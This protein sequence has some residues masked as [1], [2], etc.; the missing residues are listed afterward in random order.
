M[1]RV[2]LVAWSASCL[3]VLLFLIGVRWLRYTSWSAAPSL[4]GVLPELMV[5]DGQAFLWPWAYTTLNA[6]IVLLAVALLVVGL[7]RR[8]LD[9][10]VLRTDGRWRLTPLAVAALLGVMAW[11][12]YLFDLN[13][14]VAVVCATS[15]VLAWLTGHARVTASLPRGVLV[16]VWGG[17]FACC[18]VVA[19]DAI[20]RLTI[21][22]WTVL[23]AA[24]HRYL[25]PR[26]GAGDLAL[27]R[28]AAVI[29]MNLL[30]AAL[31][32]VLVLHGGTRL[33]EGL[34]YSFCEVPGRAVVY[35]AVP[36]CDSV[37][38]AYEDCGEGRVVEYD[39]DTLKRVAAHDFFSPEFH[40]RLELMVCLPDEVQV[41]VQS[42][43]YRG[44]SLVHSVLSFRAADP[45]E[46]NP[47]FATGIGAAMAYDGAHDAVFYSGE[48]NNFI[49]RY[50]R[51]TRQFDDGA[52]PQFVRRWFEPVSLQA[53]DGSMCIH[54]AGIHP[55]RNRMYLTEWMRGRYAYALDLNSLRQ[56]ARYDVGGGGASGVSV[57]VER[58]RLF[59]SSLW[60]LEVYDLAT[61]ALIA[62]KR[63]GLGNRPVI[64]DAARNRLYVSSTVEGKV[65]I[66][67]RDTFDVVGQIPIGIGSRFPHL[68]SDG[69]HLFASSLAA[70]YAWDADTLATR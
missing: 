34:A 56:V 49:V 63:L 20:D 39:R 14:T 33:G 24:T 57:D 28:G 22:V 64:V 5:L 23:L 38:T 62:R 8:L 60:G 41:T 32:L 43:K 59:V 36:V 53:F 55:G 35:A 31:P 61:D 67:D 51:R 26:F 11:L 7:H 44:R 42:A 17:F 46:F 70:H 21:V 66:L 48:F 65:R 9:R 13:P 16:A 10:L 25:G 54:T 1:K 18:V 68:S 58:D 27:L 40:G 45:S 15:L 2:L 50:D 4:D 6:R 29:P 3:G 47:L 12:H 30:P 37:R 69:K 19:G 52:S